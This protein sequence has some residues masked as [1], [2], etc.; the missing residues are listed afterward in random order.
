MLTQNSLDFNVRS[1]KLYAELGFFPNPACKKGHPTGK[2][3]Q[4]K[5]TISR[6]LLV[7]SVLYA[8]FMAARLPH[9]MEARHDGGDGAKGNIYAIPL[10]VIVLVG[11]FGAAVIYMLLWRPSRGWLNSVLLRDLLSGLPE[12][13]STKT[14]GTLYFL[15]LKI[16]IFQVVAAN[17]KTL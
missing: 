5:L 14:N 4:R 1:L 8:A 13:K 15:R 2:S 10:H 12:G 11:G 9:A 17:G 6:S 7:G 16:Y 3:P